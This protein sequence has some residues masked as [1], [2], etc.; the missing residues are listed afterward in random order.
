[1]LP[2]MIEQGI[3]SELDPCLLHFGLQQLIKLS[4]AQSG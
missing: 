1:M 2:Q 3:P 4:G